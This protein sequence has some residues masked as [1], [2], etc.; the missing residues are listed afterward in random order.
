MAASN[1]LNM[2]TSGVQ[3]YD[4]TTGGL[5]GSAVTQFTVQVG[6]ANNKLA[7]LGTGSSGQ[8]LQSAGA[9]SNPAY[10]TATYPSTAGTLG[11]VLT[12]DGTNWTSASSSGIGNLLIAHKTLTSSQIKNLHGTP[13]EIIAAPG[14]GK[15][16]QL[17]AFAA[18]F[19]YGG[20]NVFVAGA[21]QTVSLYLNNNTTALLGSAVSNAMIVASATKF[22]SLSPFNVGTSV[23]QVAGVVDNVNVAAYNS[24]ATEISGNAANDNTI[25]IVVSYYIVTF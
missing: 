14:S 16:I 7:S 1:S 17:I 15:A 13:I 2:D 12:S 10:S 9:G 5:D 6:A 22:S 21:A 18:R 19:N 4:A 8:V 3:T 20:T 24:V 11:N 25:D 23:N